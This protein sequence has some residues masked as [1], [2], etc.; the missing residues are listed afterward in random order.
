LTEHKFEFVLRRW[1]DFYVACAI[2]ATGSLNERRA[3]EWP[4]R[5]NE[6][7][8]IQSTETWLIDAD[9]ETERQ[10]SQATQHFK[11]MRRRFW[12]ITLWHWHYPQS[13]SATNHT[14]IDHMW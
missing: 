9:T 14:N 2:A 5:R 1:C 8:N 13:F 4:M 6:S 11:A 3:N 10:R 12:N 7:I